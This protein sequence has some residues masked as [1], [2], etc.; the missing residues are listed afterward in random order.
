MQ[1]I[2]TECCCFVEG[3][4]VSQVK[5]TEVRTHFIMTDSFSQLRK[6]GQTGLKGIIHTHQ[7]V[8]SRSCQKI[9]STNTL[10]PDKHPVTFTDLML[11]YGYLQKT[12]WTENQTV[13]CVQWPDQTKVL[14]RGRL[15]SSNPRRWGFK[16]AQ[17]WKVCVSF[18]LFLSLNPLKCA[19]KS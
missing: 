4:V 7:I 14:L 8:I 13:T 17:G 9:C 18:H 19:E 12:N 2:L 10:N 16:Y 6:T 5:P 1:N 3:G 15:D 11:H